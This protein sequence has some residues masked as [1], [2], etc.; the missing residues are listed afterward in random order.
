MRLSLLQKQE[1]AHDDSVWACAW[2]PGSNSLVTGSVDESVKLWQESAES[3]LELR[4]H[5]VGARAL[6]LHARLRGAAHPC[7]ALAS[8]RVAA[9]LAAAAGCAARDGPSPPCPRRPLQLGLSLGVVG[10]SVDGSGRY[11][12]ASSLD[13]Y[14]SVWN[15]DDYGQ[16]ALG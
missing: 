6:G 15:M 1:N 13:S 3:T 5:L 10:V 14:V 2:A 7:P 16:G 12:A 11:G 4:H 8:Q 9:H